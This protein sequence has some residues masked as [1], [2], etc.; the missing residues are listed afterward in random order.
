MQHSSESNDL[1]ALRRGQAVRRASAG[2]TA[3]SKRAPDLQW[4]RV[5]GLQMDEFEL[6]EVVV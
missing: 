3:R 4:A 1:R 2:V 5:D 6:A